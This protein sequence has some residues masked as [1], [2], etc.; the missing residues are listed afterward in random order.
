MEL[1]VAQ[2]VHLI[3]AHQTI[4]TLHLVQQIILV[5]VV[6]EQKMLQLELEE[7]V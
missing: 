5:A 1:V 7:V 4:I 2:M 3:M 6:V